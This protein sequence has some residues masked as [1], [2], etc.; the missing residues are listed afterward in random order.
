MLLQGEKYA[1]HWIEQ[2]KSMKAWVYAHIQLT[3][4]EA[5]EYKG[6]PVVYNGAVGFTFEPNE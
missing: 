1:G 2:A 3:P 5:A 6:A 4:E